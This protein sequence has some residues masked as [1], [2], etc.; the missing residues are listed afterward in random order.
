MHYSW[1]SVS[2]YHLRVL[3]WLMAHK[4][5]RTWK[6]RKERGNKQLRRL[7][8]F[9]AREIKKRRPGVLSLNLLGINYLSHPLFTILY[10]RDKQPPCQRKSQIRLQSA[11][12]SERP[13]GF[14]EYFKMQMQWS[15]RPISLVID[16]TNLKHCRAKQK[17][18]G[19]HFQNKPKFP[20]PLNESSIFHCKSGPR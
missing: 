1:L 11:Q 17:C 9:L 20:L 18:E 13:K 12:V 14:L 8:L 3:C 15:K 6:E 2:K 19:G 4:M 5:R 16:P 7:S 10:L